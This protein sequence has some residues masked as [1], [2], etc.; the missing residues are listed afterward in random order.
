MIRSAPAWRDYLT[1]EERLLVER[2][3]TAKSLWL[4]LRA[5]RATIVNRAVKRAAYAAGKLPTTRI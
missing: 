1:P 3:D 2:I 4:A 5:T